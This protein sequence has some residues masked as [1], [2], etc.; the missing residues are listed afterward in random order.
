MA[1]CLLWLLGAVFRLWWM[2]YRKYT[3][4]SSLP[5]F[6]LFSVFGFTNGSD[7][8]SNNMVHSTFHRGKNINTKILLPLNLLEAYI[9]L[10]LLYCILFCCG[11]VPGDSINSQSIINAIPKRMPVP[12]NSL[13]FHIHVHTHWLS[14]KC[15]LQP[16]IALHC[17]ALHC[18]ALHSGYWLEQ[19]C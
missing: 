9:S 4:I 19:H 18:I 17:I 14:T 6:L 8:H 5:F 7:R 12:F 13:F 3:C 15:S 16:S 11:L 10:L 2:P 1:T